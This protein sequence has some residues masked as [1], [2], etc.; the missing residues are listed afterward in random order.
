MTKAIVYTRE[1]TAQGVAK[2]WEEQ[3]RSYIR[4]GTKP[5]DFC[6]KQTLREL[7]AMGAN[8]DPDEIDSLLGNPSWTTVSCHSCSDPSATG[9][10][11]LQDYMAD[12]HDEDMTSLCK[13]CVE[14]G[15]KALASMP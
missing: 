8:P 11:F 10:H 13:S 12:I 9:V 1:T 7:K 5:G 2:R 4:K 15:V 3:Y 14:E 6:P